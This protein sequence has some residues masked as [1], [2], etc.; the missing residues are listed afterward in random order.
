MLFYVAWKIIL[1][2]YMADD[3]STLTAPCYNIATIKECNKKFSQIYMFM[4][5]HTIHVLSQSK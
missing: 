3:S 2:H 5:T 4:C 1:P